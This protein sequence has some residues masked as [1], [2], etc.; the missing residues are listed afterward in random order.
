MSLRKP[1][2]A[3]RYHNAAAGG[4]GEGSKERHTTGI[5]NR[6]AGWQPAASGMR[7]VGG[8]KGQD[9]IISSIPGYRN[10][11]EQAGG[12]APTTPMGLAPRFR[13][14]AT[15]ARQGNTLPCACFP[16]VKRSLSLKHDPGS[17]PGATA[18]ELQTRWAS[19]VSS[20]CDPI[21]N[22]GGVI[23][24]TYCCFEGM[25]FVPRLFEVCQLECLPDA[26][27]AQ[28]SEIS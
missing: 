10:C 24:N 12:R 6:T 15:N 2:V 21:I 23:G 19:M 8:S 16:A 3:S 5:C 20:V 13:L 9:P 22:S 7:T 11:P 28:F 25:S 18:Q 1:N 17:L 14:R 4:R 27:T 26:A